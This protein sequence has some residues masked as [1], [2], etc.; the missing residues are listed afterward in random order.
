MKE[1]KEGL[2]WYIFTFWD[3]LY[4]YW[5]VEYLLSYQ[6]QK[7]LCPARILSSFQDVIQSISICVWTQF[8]IH[9]TYAR[10]VT[11]SWNTRSEGML[12]AVVDIRLLNYVPIVEVNITP[13][14]I[15]SY[16]C[17]AFSS[18][19]RNGTRK[20]TTWIIMF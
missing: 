6:S 20:S 17:S 15:V 3:Y 12:L 7:L 11:Y 10:C 1:E 9:H 8:T 13:F 14:T 18:G 16:A 2:K 4:I 19:K 5:K